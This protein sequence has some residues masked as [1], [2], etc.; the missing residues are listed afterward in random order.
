MRLK[1]C[2]AAALLTSTSAIAADLSPQVAEPVAPVAVYDWTGFYAG[3]SAGY[4]HHSAEVRDISPGVAPGPFSYSADTGLGSGQIGYNYQINN[5]VLGAEGDIGYMGGDGK[6]II[7]STNAGSH[8][9]LT[10]DGGVYGDATA[11]LGYAFGPVLL[12][13][14]GGFAFFNGEAKQATTNPGYAPTGTDTFTGWTIGGGLEYLLTQN[15]SVKVEYQHFDFGEQDG[16]QTAVVADPPTPA[17]FRFLNKTELT[18]ETVKVG[19][20]YRF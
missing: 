3:V 5:F 7:G 11:R 8:Q 16:Y 17:G 13:A 18:A 19:L 14:K 10:L 20:N 9:D 2:I 1:F 12:Y 4:V 6:G 15:V